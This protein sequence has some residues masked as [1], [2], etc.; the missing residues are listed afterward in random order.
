MITPF[1][2]WINNS[3]SE[4]L[5]EARNI[6]RHSSRSSVSKE[7]NIG[8]LF[9]MYF[10]QGLETLHDCRVIVGIHVCA[11]DKKH[12]CTITDNNGA[13]WLILL[14][15]IEENQPLI[16]LIVKPDFMI[17][18]ICAGWLWSASARSRCW[19]ILISC[20]RLTFS[21]S[22]CKHTKRYMEFVHSQFQILQN[23]LKLY[24]KTMIYDK[25]WKWIN[26]S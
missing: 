12:C 4:C 26:R 1:K 10:P 6:F 5:P 14:N 25:R 23:H 15:V 18:S 11:T 2:L 22:L 16:S 9:V 24:F 3:K 17:C 13:R 20:H 19:R 8:P 21:V 7:H